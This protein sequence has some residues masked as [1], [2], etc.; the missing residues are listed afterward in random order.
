MSRGDWVVALMLGTIA[1]TLVYLDTEDY[2]EYGHGGSARMSIPKMSI[3]IMST[4][5]KCIL[6]KCLLF[7]AHALSSQKV[8]GPIM[9][10]VTLC[11][12]IYTCA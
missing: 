8:L 3:L 5:Q 10:I 11:Y 7:K 4:V 2:K 1:T 6:P 12:T 9:S